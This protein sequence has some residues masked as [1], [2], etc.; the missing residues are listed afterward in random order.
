[1]G[2]AESRELVLR[3]I[4]SRIR[5]LASDV[6]GLSPSAGQ[7]PALLWAPPSGSSGP[8]APCSGISPLPS[9][10]SR[11]GEAGGDTLGLRLVEAPEINFNKP[12]FSF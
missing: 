1:M 12:F 7:E 9:S 3:R 10:I 2:T 4:A 5:D 8:T 6:A 11:V